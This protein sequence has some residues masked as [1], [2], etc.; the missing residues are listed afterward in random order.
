MQKLNATLEEDVHA[1]VKRKNEAD[2]CQQKDNKTSKSFTTRQ[3]I[4]TVDKKTESEKLCKHSLI[5]KK[6]LTC[7]QYCQ[8]NKRKN[9]CQPCTTEKKEKRSYLLNLCKHM[10][11]QKKCKTCRKYCIHNKVQ[12]N[13]VTCGGKGLC[14]HK[15]QRSQCAACSGGSVCQH[16]KLRSRCVFC[17]GGSLCQHKK[18]KTCCVACA[19]ASTCAHKLQK[20]NCRECNPSAFCIHDKKKYDCPACKGLGVCEHNTTRRNCSKCSTWR[21]CRHKLRRDSC[22]ECLSL[23][24]MIK[25]KRWCIGC[26]DKMLNSQRV[27]AGIR[28]CA[29]CDPRVPARVEHVVMPM[30][31][32]EIG[33]PASATDNIIIGGKECDTSKRR[34]DGCWISADGRIAFLE[35]D[36]SGH[37]DRDMSC[38]VAKVIDQTESVCH[39]YP[40]FIVVHFRFNPSAF[41]RKGVSLK[42]RVVKTAH[43]ICLFLSGVGD[44]WRPEIP[45]I[46]YYYYPKKS[47]FQ[48]EHALNKASDALCV[49]VV[50]NDIFRYATNLDDV[51]AT[52]TKIGGK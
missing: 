14:I 47:H 41:D 12:T 2:I 42:E 37:V 29:T 22:K 7:K 45:H 3:K 11:V 18:M 35:I 23:D 19:G 17:G 13:C 25:S 30:F 5:R 43:D 49:L 15:K 28:V 31:D 50:D 9:T 26:G 34:P 44:T 32:S 27:R 1:T 52:W 36:E 10:L 40:G 24:D 46:L 16:K 48:I 6:C 38:E 20:T 51:C 21:I 8:H 33:F 39:A 4:E